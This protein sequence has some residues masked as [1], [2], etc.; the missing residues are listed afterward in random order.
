MYGKVIDI[1]DSDQ[2]D[3]IYNVPSGLQHSR[4]KCA[5]A[6]ILIANV[7]G[8]SIPNFSFNADSSDDEMDRQLQSLHRR[9]ITAFKTAIICKKQQKHQFSKRHYRDFHSATTAI[10]SIYEDNIVTS[11][12]G[13]T[14]TS[15]N[16]RE[17]IK[18]SMPLLDGSSKDH[19]ICLLSEDENTYREPIGAIRRLK[20]KCMKSVS[21]SN[22]KD[23]KSQV[24]SFELSREPVANKVQSNS[25]AFEE[26]HNSIINARKVTSNRLKRQRETHMDVKKESSTI[27]NQRR[28]CRVASLDQKLKQ[29]SEGDSDENEKYVMHNVSHLDRIDFD[30][31]SLPVRQF[32]VHTHIDGTFHLSP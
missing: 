8:T 16:T 15:I 12:S 18:M 30:E 23:F 21:K 13:I 28:L 27:R 10:A 3:S 26:E 7:S 11:E 9:K 4:H 14:S 25:N 19:A 24:T 22:N 20:K 29:S 5:G 31:N 32:T 2:S 1:L 17:K 6:S